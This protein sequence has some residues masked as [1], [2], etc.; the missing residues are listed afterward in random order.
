[1]TSLRWIKILLTSLMGIFLVV[2]SFNYIVDPYGLYNV[3]VFKDKPKADTKS[4]LSTP[5]RVKKIKPA[6]VILGS[7][8]VYYAYN[9][10]HQIFIKP[11]LNT[12]FSGGNIHEAM[13]ILDYSIKQGNLKRAVLM[14]DWEMFFPEV[15]NTAPDFDEYFNDPNIY[16]Y[17]LTVQTFRASVDTIRKQNNPIEINSLFKKSNINIDADE[18]ILSVPDSDK[19]GNYNHIKI[20]HKTEQRSYIKNLANYIY[21]DLMYSSLDDFEAILKMS[22][23]NN[24]ELFLGIG[25]SHIRLWEALDYRRGYDKWLNWKKDIVG[26][27]EKVARELNKQPFEIIDFAIYHEITSEEFPQDPKIAMQYY[28]ESSHYT[29]KLA[30]IVLDRL[31]GINGY[32]D[33]GVVINNSNIDS[34]LEKLKQDRAKYIDTKAYR[35][36]VFGEK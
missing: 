35:L 10:K 1:M 6:S 32:E 2:I 7:S 8:R 19:D 11:A 26:I 9:T 30:N 17:L 34:H 18:N 13:K 23:E 24:V 3:N 15:A 33:F 16:K 27:T 21:R 28:K 36:E 14:L 5:L 4:R 29:T 31:L 25:P 22:Y 12:S 20:T